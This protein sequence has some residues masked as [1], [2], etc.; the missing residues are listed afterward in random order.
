[1]LFTPKY[2]FFNQ[3]FSRFLGEKPFTCNVCEKSFADKSNLRAHV[4]TH[5]NTKPFVCS[6]CHKAFALKS[7]LY[8]HEESS[9][10]KMFKGRR[11]GGGKTSDCQSEN[12]QCHQDVSIDQSR[13]LSIDPSRDLSIDPSR[14]ISLEQSRDVSADQYFKERAAFLLAAASVSPSQS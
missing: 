12:E 9:C 11:Q 7:Y 8:K 14:E 4:Q 1:V 10:M 3:I 13:D 6:R 2:L 5:S